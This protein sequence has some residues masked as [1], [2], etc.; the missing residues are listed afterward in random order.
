MQYFKILLILLLTSSCQYFETEKISTETF[1]NEE[2]KAI[3][4]KDVDQYP[5]FSNCE[6]L[7]EKATQKACFENTLSAHLGQAF[8]KNNFKAIRELNDT[9]KLSLSID[10]KGKLSITNISITPLI[11]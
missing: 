8:T 4:W 6:K 9:I 1:Y 10:N 3:D 11:R 5:T 2:L 7:T